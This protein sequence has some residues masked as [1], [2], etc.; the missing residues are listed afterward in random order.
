MLAGAKIEVVSVEGKDRGVR[1]RAEIQCGE[2]IEV[3]HVTVLQSDLTEFIIK[4]HQHDVFFSWNPEHSR[5]NLAVVFGL[6]SLCN[7]SLTPNA[8]VEREFEARLVTLIASKDI[9]AGEEILI[10][11]IKPR[12]DYAETDAPAPRGWSSAK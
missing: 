1:A 3:A 4:H 6:T 11:Y 10:N 8:Y 5:E 2:V 9:E 7:H 12:E